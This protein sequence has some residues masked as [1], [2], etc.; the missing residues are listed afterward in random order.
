MDPCG[1]SEERYSGTNDASPTRVTWDLQDRQESNHLIYS[2]WIKSTLLEF[3]GE[4]VMVHRVK[5]FR[6]I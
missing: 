1:T 6:N 2:I 5:C 4:E 3:P